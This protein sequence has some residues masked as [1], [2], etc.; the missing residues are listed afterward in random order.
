MA[1]K[2]FSLEP[3]LSNLNKTRKSSNPSVSQVSENSKK[4][5]ED[6]FQKF[7]D[8]YFN[9]SKIMKSSSTN[10]ETS[11]VEIPSNE[12]E[13]FHESSESFQEESSSSSLNNDVHQSSEEV[14]VPSSNTQSISNNMVPNVDKASTS[15]NVFNEHLKDAY[16]DASTSFHD[17]SDGESS[18]SSLNDDV[19]QS[20]EEVII[21]SSNTQSIPI[22]MISNGDEASTSHNVFNERLEDAYFD[23][24]TPFH[25]PLVPRPEGKSVIKTKWIFKNKKDEI[26]LVIRN[27]ARLVAVGYSQQEG[28]DYD[29]MFAPVARIEAIRLFLAYAAHKD[30]TAFQIDVKTTFLNGIIKEEVYVG[31]PSGFVSKQYPDHVY[32]LD[33]ALYAVKRIFRYLKRTINLGLWYSKDSGFDLTAYSD[34]DHAGCH[35]DQKSASGSVQFL[36]DKLVYWSSKKHNCVSISIVESKYVAVSSCCAQVLWMRTQLTDYGFFYDKVPIYCDSKSAIAISCNPVQHTRTKH[37]DVRQGLQVAYLLIYVD[38]II[39]IASCPALLQHIIGSLN[40]KFDMTD[41][42]ALNYFLGISADRTPTSLLLSQKRSYFV[43]QPCRRLQ[44]LTFTRLDLSYAVQQICLHMH[45]PREPHFAALK[46]I[47]RYVRGTVDFGLHLYVFATT[48]LVGYTDADWAGCPSTHS[49][50]SGYCVYL[51]DNLLSW[52][53]K[54]QH[55]ISRS[56]AEAEYQGVANVVTKIAWVRNLLCELHSPLMTTTLVYC[57]NFSAVY[58]SANPIQHQQTKHI[59]IDIHFVCD[60]VSAGHVRVLHIEEEEDNDFLRDKMIVCVLM[61]RFSCMGEWYGKKV[62]CDGNVRKVEEFAMCDGVIALLGGLYRARERL[63]SSPNHPTSDIEDAFPFNFPDYTPASPDYFPAL[64]VNT[65]YGFVPIA[66]PTLLLFHD[67]PYMKVMH[68]YD[69]IMPP[70]VPIPPPIIVP[71]SPMLS[72]IFN[73]QKFFVIEELLPPKEQVSKSSMKMHLKHHEKQIEDILNYLEELSFHRIEKMEERL[74]NGWMIIQRDFDELK[75]EL[76]K[77]RSQISKLQKKHT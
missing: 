20:P 10:V 26:S 66:S 7:Y 57:D 34:A 71:P 16:F 53:D 15:H 23:A 37:I 54:R 48:S 19:Q 68:A 11:N 73:L 42:G 24:S 36:G 75:T 65:S 27:K 64:P 70:Q 3:G 39:L 6:L 17:P 67:D 41:L 59:E 4:D 32:A 51:G 77:V 12:E 43:S 38:D 33:K 22:N 56:S 2:Q 29:E 9:S 21:P 52:S 60:M 76:E 49:S 5:L 13:V 35:L 28:I 62:R 30:F 14:R 1:S 31:Q 63:M 72:P 18:S 25:D 58:M 46:C 8:E 44:Y 40:N 50:T 69:A 47:L 74:V 45:D 61:R 55:T